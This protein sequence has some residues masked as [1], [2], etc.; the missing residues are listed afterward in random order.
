VNALPSAPVPFPVEVIVLSSFRTEW[1]ADHPFPIVSPALSSRAFVRLVTKERPPTYAHLVRADV[2]LNSNTEGLKMGRPVGI[3]ILFCLLAQA[4][5]TFDLSADFSLR[6]NP[7]Q[8]W[9]YGYSETN[10]L[11]P[12]Q[13]RIDKSTGASVN[14][15]A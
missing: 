2:I 1:I 6:N 13:F 4:A 3:V 10:S 8:A 11:D 9:Q 15:T 12:A 7:N 14:V 5:T